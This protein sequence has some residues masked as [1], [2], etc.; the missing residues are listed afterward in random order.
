[1]NFVGKGKNH[2]GLQCGDMKQYINSQVG[3]VTKTG[4]VMAGGLGGYRKD[5]G[6]SEELGLH[7]GATRRS[8]LGG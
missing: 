6:L 1:M 3:R 4:E 7:V 8:Q 5:E 2:T